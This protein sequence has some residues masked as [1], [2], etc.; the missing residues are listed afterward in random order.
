MGGGAET[1]LNLEVNSSIPICYGSSF[2]PHDELILLEVDDA[3]LPQFLDDRFSCSTGEEERS[4]IYYDFDFRLRGLSFVS[5]VYDWVVIRGEPDEEAVLCTSSKTYALKFVSTSNSVFLVPPNGCHSVGA[6]T[7]TEMDV[8]DSAA[9]VVKLA[10]GHMEL[11]LVAPKLEK[12]KTLLKQ[13]V[14]KGDYDDCESD[15]KLG[16]YTWQDLADRIQASD[17]ELRDGLRAISAVEIDG[18][19]RLVDD[20]LMEELLTMMFRNLDIHGWSSNALR[21]EEVLPVMVDDGYSPTLVLHCLNTN[22]SKEEKEEGHIWCLN[23]RMVAVFY[24]RRVLGRC[25]KRKEVDF[26]EEWKRTVPSGIDVSMGML[27]GEVLTEKIGVDTWVRGFSVSS[28][29]STPAERFAALF[30]ERQRWEWQHLEP[31]VRLK[32]FSSSVMDLRVPG[33]SSEGL[34]I[35]YTRRTQPTADAAPIFSAR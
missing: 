24:G 25:G 8:T 1:L 23:Q 5:L 12:L 7:E 19:W 4:L 16:L 3:L 9:S 32:M 2:G 13:R 22:G 11:V 20:G 35:K 17:D 6:E 10:P 29:P 34:L 30:R 14:Y 27:E 18:Y 31:F 28:L 26:M 33:L 21:E 15:S